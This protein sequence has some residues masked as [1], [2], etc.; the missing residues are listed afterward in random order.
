MRPLKW[1]VLV[2]E[3]VGYGENRNWQVTEMRPADDFE[4]ALVSAEQTAQDH[5]PTHPSWPKSRSLF[6]TQDG[7][8]LVTVEGATTT[9]HFRVSVAEYYGTFPRKPSA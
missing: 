7:G 4:Q 5:Q 2:E 9:F 8:W 6:R 3:N 1:Y